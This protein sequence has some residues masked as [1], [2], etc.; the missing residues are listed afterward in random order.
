MAESLPYKQD[1]CWFESSRAHHEY[2][3]GAIAQTGRAPAL[4]AGRRGFDSLWLHQSGPVA[5]LAEQ[6]F[7]KPQVVG[8]DPTG[9]SMRKGEIG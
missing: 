9:A 5:Q 4:H 8:S 7:C 1:T 3:S 6:W 2:I